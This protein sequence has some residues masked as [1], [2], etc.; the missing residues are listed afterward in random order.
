LTP[1]IRLGSYEIISAIGAGGMGEVYRATDSNLKRS[2]AIKVLPASVAGD[3]DRLARFQ[4][5][6][7][8]LAALNHPNIAAI[9]GL[10][11]T[12]DLTALVMELVE[13]EDLSA[14]IAR[15]PIALADALPIAKQIADALEAAHEQ[16]IIHRDLKPANIKVRADG[17]VKVLDFGLAK[18]MDPAGTS[19]GDAMNSPTM[20]A[21]ATQMGMI[22]GTA[23]YMAPEQARG[24]VVDRRADIWAF[25]VVLYEMLTGQRAFEGEDISITLASVLKEDVRWVALPD[26]LPAPALRLLRRC[27]EKDPRRRL[28]WIG[29]ARLTLEDPATL[30]PAVAAALVT[31]A[32]A[33]PA[34][35]LWRRAL[36]WAV[37]VALGAALVAAVLAWAPWRTAPAP[38]PRKLLASIGT[39]AGLSTTLG[40]AAILSP[41]GTTLA[42]TAVPARQT[43]PT[44]FVRKLDELQAMALSGTEDATSPFFSPDGQWIAYFAGGQLKKVSTTGGASIKLCDAPNGRGGTWTDDDTIIFTPDNSSTMRLMRV[45]AAGGAA[46]VFGTLGTS[47]TTQ[48]WPQ[49]LP[50]GRSVLYTEHSATGNFDA[51]NLVVAPI[52]GSSAEA[53]AKAG[54]APKVVVRGGY[55]G[56]YVSSDLGSSMSGPGSPKR[57]Q[58]GGG[59][60]LIY[61]NQGTLFAVRFDLDRLEIIGP[62][63]PAIEGIATLQATVGGAQLAISADGTIVYVPGIVSAAA[64]PIDWL[65]RDGKTSPLRADKA[66]WANPRFSPDGQKLTIDISDGKQRDV[67]VYDVARGTLTQLT[68]DAANDAKPVWTPDGRRIVF[69][70]DRV[71]PGVPNMYWMSADG[72]GQVS[73]LTDSP[74]IQWPYSWHPSAKSLA[75]AETRGATGADLMIL[76]MEGDA[77]RGWTPGTPTVF[78]GTKA[79]EAAPRFSPDG[80]FITY[81]S[82]AES[83]GPTFDIY[84]RPF[85]GSGGPWRVS[86]TGGVYP[87]WSAPTHE[88]LFANYLDPTPSKIMAAPYAVVGDS[89]QAQTPKVWSSTSVQRVVPSN[90]AYDLH[91]DGKRIAA[92]AVVDQSGI[93]QDKVV[94]VFNFAEYLAKI[95]PGKK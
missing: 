6:A 12:P 20:T 71:K 29:E 2:V 70:S 48:R 77:T 85:Q 9:Y 25:G 64:T 35:P 63:V 95:A 49:A 38:T 92:A 89:F 52:S 43:R 40:A 31:V 8:V 21:R 4:R 28:S 56:R 69:A 10:E 72:T 57:D 27:L 7:E 84:V 24:R 65:S 42:F 37:A 32:P 68:F 5:E 23:A 44:L 11:K 80:R 16:G 86:T 51:A 55:Y 90:S 14:V 61:M 50:G 18:A 88:L 60:H 83:G 74:N 91:P 53:S 75:F 30:Q 59:G 47:A 17:T 33:S 26:N 73:R 39:D 34:A 93:V 22:L 19:S 13:G 66:D 1:G 41:D 3:A 58:R 79:T 82:T 81:T 54:G 15:G 45:P 67:W 36:P 78:L 76:P 62:A 94:F 46:A 87:E